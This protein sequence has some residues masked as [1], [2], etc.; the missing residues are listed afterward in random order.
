MPRKYGSRGPECYKYYSV[1]NRKTDEAVVIHRT[2]QECADI[3]GIK[4]S[5]F[6]HYVNRN[7]TGKL[8]CKYDIFI[9]DPEEDEDG[10]A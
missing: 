4:R 10:E 9:D 8:Y 6:Y 1:Y 2:S 5:S 7:K 3:M